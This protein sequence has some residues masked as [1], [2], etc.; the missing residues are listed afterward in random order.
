MALIWTKQLS[1]G[2]AMLDFEHKNLIGMVNSV[3][4]AIKNRD[5]FALLQ[6]IKLLLDSVQSHFANEERFARAID[7]PFDQ[8]RLLHQHLQ[9]ELQ[10]TWN[11]LDIKRGMWVEHVMDHYPQFL[12]EWLVDHIAKEDMAMKQTLQSHPYDFK[13]D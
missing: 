9:K 7:L 10:S 8:H 5:S 2:N 11:E 1:I 12:R 3:E 13:P 6:T 4:Y